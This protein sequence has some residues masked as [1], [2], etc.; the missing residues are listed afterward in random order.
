MQPA[1]LVALGVAALIAVCLVLIMGWV[2][3]APEGFE[4]ESGFH[5]KP[6]KTTRRFAATNP[7]PANG[8]WATSIR[9]SLT[10]ST[11]RHAR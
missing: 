8:N 3:S 6:I 11:G 5:A 1:I 4:D 7:S 10:D 9:F 2:S